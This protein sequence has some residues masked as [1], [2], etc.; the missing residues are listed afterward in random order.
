MGQALVHNSKDYSC[1]TYRIRFLQRVNDQLLQQIRVLEADMNKRKQ[2]N[3]QPLST[4]IYKLHDF[5]TQFLF[6]LAEIN[7]CQNFYL[8]DEF[9]NMN[10]RHYKEM[11]RNYFQI[12]MEKYNSYLK[13]KRL[14]MI[15]NDLCKNIDDFK[16]DDDDDCNNDD[17]DHDIDFL[18]S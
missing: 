1:Y 2:Q 12:Y 15:K 17:N 10:G 8:G 14:N 9:Y 4:D 5:T 11:C 16:H 7:V 13:E 3:Q 6:S 18:I